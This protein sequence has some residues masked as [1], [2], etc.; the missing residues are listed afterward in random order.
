MY[1]FILLKIKY[2]LEQNFMFCWN[3]NKICGISKQNL[4]FS[5]TKI[6]TIIFFPKIVCLKEWN[7]FPQISHLWAVLSHIIMIQNQ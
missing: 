7:P 4:W 5:T 6:P 3:E 2:E 1:F